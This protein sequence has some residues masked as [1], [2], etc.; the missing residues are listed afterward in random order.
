MF[1]AR[2]LP[3]AMLLLS[4]LGIG[5][6]LLYARRHPG[7]SR[8]ELAMQHFLDSVVRADDARF[9]FE[10]RNAV[11]V[12]MDEDTSNGEHTSCIL[13]VC[14]TNRYGEYFSFRSDGHK[15]FVRHL[16]HR[17]ARIILKHE[18]AGP[19]PAGRCVGVADEN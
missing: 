10:S 14:A 19:E 1:D 7:V 12:R 17:L 5:A 2:F 15:P 8:V 3:G 9:A 11:I 16:E 13:T 18:Y 4:A 6:C